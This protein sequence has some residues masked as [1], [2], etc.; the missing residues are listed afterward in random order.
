MDIDLHRSHPIETPPKIS[1]G[2]ATTTACAESYKQNHASIHLPKIDRNRHDN[3]L[4]HDL[5]IARGTPIN[6]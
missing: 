1:F 5:M 4:R 2:I 3:E 6:A